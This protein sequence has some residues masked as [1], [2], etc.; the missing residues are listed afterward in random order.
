MSDRLADVRPTD[1]GSLTSPAKNDI[2]QIEMLD[3][4]QSL[5]EE[6]KESTTNSSAALLSAYAGLTTNETIVKFKRLFLA[7]FLVSFSGVYLGFTLNV[8]GSVIANRGEQMRGSS[9]GS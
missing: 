4:C 9:L 8:P 7:G 2:E 3:R 1:D 5:S 6:T